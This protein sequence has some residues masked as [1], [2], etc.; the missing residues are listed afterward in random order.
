MD[1]AYVQIHRHVYLKRKQN[2]GYQLYFNE[3]KKEM[4][5]KQRENLGKT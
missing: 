1:Y 2:F 3:A 5:Y 4:G